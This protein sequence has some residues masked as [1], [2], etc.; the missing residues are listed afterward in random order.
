MA[1]GPCHQQRS[2]QSA[3]DPLPRARAD[4]ELPQS[5]GASL[6]GRRS[7]V[8]RRAF[9]QPP[10]EKYLVLRRRDKRMLWRKSRYTPRPCSSEYPDWLAP[11][12]DLSG[13]VKPGDPQG[14]SIRSPATQLPLKRPVPIAQLIVLAD[15]QHRNQAPESG[16]K[17]M[18]SLKPPGVY[19]WAIESSPDF[20]EI[21][22]W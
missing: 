19:R 7:N 22:S 3:R 4:R 13:A 9:R 12:L 1:S 6:H 15:Q 18:K 11:F 2:Y 10:P 5:S 14:L 17:R 20:R 21:R 16:V 8:R